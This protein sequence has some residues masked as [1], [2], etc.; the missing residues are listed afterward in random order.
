MKQRL[1]CAM[2]WIVVACFYV[3]RAISHAIR[4]RSGRALLFNIFFSEKLLLLF[5]W[6]TKIL[7]M[8]LKRMS[9]GFLIRFAA[10]IVPHS[11]WPDQGMLFECLFMLVSQQYVI[12]WWKNRHGCAVASF[13]T[14]FRWSQGPHSTV[15][16]MS[17]DA[18]KVNIW[19]FVHQKVPHKFSMIS[20]KFRKS[21]LIFNFDKMTDC[22][23]RSTFYGSV[24]FTDGI[25]TVTRDVSHRWCEWS[26]HRA[27]SWDSILSRYRVHVQTCYGSH[28]W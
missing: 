3:I 1:R 6:I 5:Q 19:S 20:F 11:H 22:K 16:L 9:C 27:L 8:K 21:F 14:L 26:H 24:M 28:V 13:S 25:P 23:T 7:D 10:D 18:K 15:W 17:N 4:T 2:L 12:Q